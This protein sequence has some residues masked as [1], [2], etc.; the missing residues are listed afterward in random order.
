MNG[1]RADTSS[2]A[3]GAIPGAGDTADTDAAPGTGSDGAASALD[4]AVTFNGNDGPPTAGGGGTPGPRAP[5]DTS[6]ETDGETFTAPVFCTGGVNV[7]PA[8]NTGGAA[9]AGIGLLATNDATNTNAVTGP[10]RRNRRANRPTLNHDTVDQTRPCATATPRSSRLRKR[11]NVTATPAGA[12]NYFA[13][14]HNAV[15]AGQSAARRDRP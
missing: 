1:V 9:A 15:R 6:V 7:A 8:G 12:Q 2:T 3:P 4:A 11:L 14:P 10:A 13:P 5:W